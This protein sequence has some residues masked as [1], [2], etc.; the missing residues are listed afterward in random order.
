MV[1]VSRL[2]SS[3][4]STPRSRIL[5][6][7]SKWSRFAFC[8][9][10]TS[11][12]SRSSQLVGV[13]RSCASPGAP[14]RTFRSVPTSEWTPSVVGAVMAQFLLDGYCAGR[15]T[16]DSGDSADQ[17]GGEEHGLPQREES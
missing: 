4:T 17:D 12:K 7:K 2:C 9:H 6:I 1:S 11:S 15:E 5:S 16:D 3:T 8:T 14:T 13:N 10:N